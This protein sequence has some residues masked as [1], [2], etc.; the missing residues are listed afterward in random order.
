VGVYCVADAV[1]SSMMRC[2]CRFIIRGDYIARMKSPHP[3]EELLVIPSFG[4][5]PPSPDWSLPG[6][7]MITYN[8]QGVNSPATKGRQAPFRGRWQ[9]LSE[10]RTATALTASRASRRTAPGNGGGRMSHSTTQNS[11]NKDS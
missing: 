11:K 6:N 10:Y 5:T 4:A 3:I 9:A 2:E 7:H 1:T 8:L